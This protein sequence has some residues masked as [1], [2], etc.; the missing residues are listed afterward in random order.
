MRRFGQYARL[1]PDMAEEYERLHA[2]VWPDVL[3]IIRECNLR[4]YSIY[5]AGEELFAYFEYAGTD[6]EADMSKMAADPVTRLWWTHTH[7]CFVREDPEVFYRDMKEI[8]HCE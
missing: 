2:A 4:N 6:F 7:P 5:R 8:F 3:K 1:K